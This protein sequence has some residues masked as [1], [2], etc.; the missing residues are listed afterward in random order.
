MPDREG[1]LFPVERTSGGTVLTPE[2]PEDEVVA[3]FVGRLDSEVDT[4]LS[5]SDGQAGGVAVNQGRS[6]E[7]HR[8]R[9]PRRKPRW[10]GRSGAVSVAMPG[11]RYRAQ[12]L[13]RT[14]RGLGAAADVIERALA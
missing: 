8:R 2:M 5:A 4:L 6:E 13:P 12:R 9:G 11:S 10:R 3:V 7:G 14:K 1:M